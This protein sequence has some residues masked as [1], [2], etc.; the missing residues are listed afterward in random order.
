MYSK[1]FFIFRSLVMLQK[2]NIKIKKKK[3]KRKPVNAKV[4]E[5]I[6]ADG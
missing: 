6:I 5:T 2:R 4:K 1:L 3:R